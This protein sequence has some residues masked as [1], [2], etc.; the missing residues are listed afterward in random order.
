MIEIAQLTP[1]QQ[2]HQEL[3]QN[4]YIIINLLNEN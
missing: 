3:D 1:N 4:G 2:I